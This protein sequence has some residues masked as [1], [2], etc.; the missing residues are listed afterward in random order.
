[1]S[2]LNDSRKGKCVVNIISASSV[3]PA[4]I[5]TRP[6]RVI[7]FK[8]EHPIHPYVV[9]YQAID[10]ETGEG[11]DRWTGTYTASIAEAGAEFETRCKKHRLYDAS[12]SS[13]YDPENGWVE[14][15]A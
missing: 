6:F 10:P 8:R 14:V 3:R 15:T 1:M 7:L 13:I 5:G 12:L 4:E 9:H 2:K 11:G